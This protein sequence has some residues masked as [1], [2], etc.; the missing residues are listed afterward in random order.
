MRRRR[1]RLGRI[2]TLSL[3]IGPSSP[4]GSAG[5]GGLKPVR[6]D[7]ALPLPHRPSSLPPGSAGYAVDPR[8]PGGVGGGGG[9]RGAAAEEGG[10][11]EWSLQDVL[12][13]WNAPVHSWT[14]TASEAI[15][16]LLPLA[17]YAPLL[18]P[19]GSQL[20]YARTSVRSPR[21]LNQRLTH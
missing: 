18:V 11:G 3:P 10:E 7:A 17:K 15:N 4:S 20:P 6:L 1:S 2:A 13:L 9:K 21:K 12:V 19:H 5:A 16:L 14:G 8:D